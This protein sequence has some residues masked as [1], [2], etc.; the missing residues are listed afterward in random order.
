M[1]EENQPINDA[2]QE[3]ELFMH[4]IYGCF[5]GG[6]LSAGLTSLVGLI[7]AYVKRADVQ[8]TY[9]AS[10]VTWTIR[11]FWWG[12]LFMIIS[13]IGK[14]LFTITLIFIFVNNVFFLLTGI[15]FIYRIAKGWMALS[16]QQPISNPTDI[17]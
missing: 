8:T 2:Q 17:F 3:P 14:I 7:I 13:L 4:V 16:K 10:H 1:L 9:L 6:F 15:W 12:L 11:T 5:V